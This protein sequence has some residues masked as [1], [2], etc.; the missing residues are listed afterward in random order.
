MNGFLIVA[1]IINLVYNIPQMVKTYKSKSTRDFSAWFIFLRI[2]GNM[3]WIA[4]AI[5]IDS[6]QMLVNNCVTVAASIFIGYYKCVELYNGYY[7]HTPAVYE[8]LDRCVN[9][10]RY[11]NGYSHNDVHSNGDDDRYSNDDDDAVVTV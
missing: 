10:D 3:V 8:D 7:H 9:G 1:N 5:D 4:Y 2:A 6:L 11:I